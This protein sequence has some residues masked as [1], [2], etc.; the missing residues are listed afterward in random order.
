MKKVISLVIAVACISGIKAQYVGDAIRY[1]QEFPTLSARSLAMGGAFTSLGGDFSSSY[2]NPA[3]LGLYRKSEF[4]ISPYLGLSNT[5]ADYLG[6]TNTDFKYQFNLSNVGYV[7]TYLTN[8]SKGLVSATYAIGYNRRNNFNNYSYIR[9]LNSQTSLVDNFMMELDGTDPEN[10][11]AFT[12]RLAFD[13]YLIDT[14]PGS[15]FLY[16]TPVLLPVDQ[17]R[18]VSTRG[19]TGQWNF[20]FGLNFSDVWYVGFGLGLN[21]LSLEQE[22]NHSEF[23]RATADTDFDNFIY[24][25]N[26]DVEGTGI[27][28]TFGTMVRLF[29]IMRLGASIHLPTY[30]KFDEAYSNSI[31]SEFKSGFIPSDQNGDIFAE[32]AF[33]YKLVT[34]L[35]LMGGASVQIGKM[36]II[37]ADVE[38]IDY[39]RMRLRERDDVTDFQADNEQIQDAYRSVV[40]LKLGGEARFNNLFVRLGG[41]LYPSPYSSWEL[42]K[43]AGRGEV[44]A[45]LGYRSSSFFFDLGFS[46]LFHEE[47][48]RLYSA[49]EYNPDPQAEPVMIDHISDLNQMKY[50]FVASV[51]FRF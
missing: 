43:N 41:G 2:I 15:D 27:N 49:Y 46:A 16:D 34:P 36:G 18:T 35:K 24:T 31:Y 20:S 17:R 44:T 39:S 10:L 50:R 40:N 8:N 21:R 1:S 25:E 11:D 37:A 14:I 51:G 33:R 48:Y 6:E 29:E 32:G 28:F 4:V 38:F 45:G 42:N 47:K 23:D 7:G 12:N 5:S 9:G 26:L 19:G 13:A 30:Y 3:G 22:I